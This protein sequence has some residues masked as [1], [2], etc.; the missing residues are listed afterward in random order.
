[1]DHTPGAEPGSAAVPTGVEDTASALSVFALQLVLHALSTNSRAG[2]DSEAE[3]QGD[4]VLLFV[5]KSVHRCASLRHTRLKV[6]SIRYSFGHNF[7]IFQLI[8]FF[9]RAK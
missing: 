8:L 6:S 2:E 5:L 4:R 7:S 3:G 1:M 9:W